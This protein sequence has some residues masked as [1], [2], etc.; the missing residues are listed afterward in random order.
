MGDKNE[1]CRRSPCLWSADYE[2]VVRTVRRR[3]KKKKKDRK[4]TDWFESK[5]C[6]EGSKEDAEIE[7]KEASLRWLSGLVEE[8]EPTTGSSDGCRV[9]DSTH[10]LT[11]PLLCVRF[12]SSS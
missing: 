6:C 3:Q 10:S 4:S 5:L 9:R 12:Y 8:K 2:V 7:N 1:F 11:H